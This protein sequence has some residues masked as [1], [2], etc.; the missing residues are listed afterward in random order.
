MSYIEREALKENIK[1]F[2]GKFTDDGFFVDINAVLNAIDFAP[3]A[4]VVPVVRCKD[5]RRCD[6]RRKKGV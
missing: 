3:A 2:A 1:S 6:S 5:C 4:D